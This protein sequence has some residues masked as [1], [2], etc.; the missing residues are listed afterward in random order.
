MSQ[1]VIIST[2]G[3]LCGY[4]SLHIEAI[5][6]L[7][8][9]GFTWFLYHIGVDSYVVCST[10]MGNARASMCGIDSRTFHA[11]LCLYF[12]P[13]QLRTYWKPIWHTKMRKIYV[14]NRDDLFV[15]DLEQI[16]CFEAKDDYTIAYYLSGMNSTITMGLHGI[17]ELVSKVPVSVGCDFARIGRSHVVNQVYIHQINVQRR[18]LVLSDCKHTINITIS[19]EALKKFKQSFADKYLGKLTD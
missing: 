9:C 11:F 10:I 14:N 17:E 3:S 6:W 7:V 18:R 13:Y 19:K 15:L 1:G 2:R 16:A 4:N 5:L 12:I 8:I